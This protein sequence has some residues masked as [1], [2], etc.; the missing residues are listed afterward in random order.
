MTVVALKRL[1]ADTLILENLLVRLT[2][3]E[4][5]SFIVSFDSGL[6]SLREDTSTM[7]PP[8]APQRRS[9]HR[10]NSMGYPLEFPRNTD[11]FS[12]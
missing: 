5:K 8:Q 7:V 9:A 4:P 2:T 3:D 1:I 10:S 6:A 12:K 11:L